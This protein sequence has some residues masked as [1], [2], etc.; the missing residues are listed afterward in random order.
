MDKKKGIAMVLL[1]TVVIVVIGI[2]LYLQTAEKVEVDTV[3]KTDIYRTVEDTGKV[4]SE[5]TIDL[6]AVGNGKILSIEVE[7]GDNV[8]VGDLLVLIQY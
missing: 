8:K 5:R 4:K 1:T 3:I 2:F 6:K 7:P